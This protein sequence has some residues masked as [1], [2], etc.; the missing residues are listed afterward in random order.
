[1]L[2]EV[3]ED[4]RASAVEVS[5][6]IG[7]RNRGL[8]LSDCLR[9]LMAQTSAAPF[10]IVVVD[11]SSVDSTA[12]VIEGWRRRDDRIRLVAE[13]RIGLSC[14]KNAGIRS[15]RGDLLIFTDDDVVAPAGWVSSYVDLFRRRPDAMMA[16]GPVLPIQHDL[17]RGSRWLDQTLFADIKHMHR[18]AEEH[19]LP[20]SELAFGA[21]MAVRRRLFEEIGEFDESVGPP[22][23]DSWEDLEFVSRFRAAG[24]QPWYCPGALVYHRVS[25]RRLLAVVFSHGAND[26]LKARRGAPYR[27]R[28]PVPRGRVQAS[29]VLPWSL[30]LLVLSGGV[31]RL[32]GRP[33]TFRLARGLAWASGW[34]MSAAAWNSSGWRPGRMARILRRLSLLGRRLALRL[35]PG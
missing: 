2:D 30:A 11:N 25:P 28:V 16:G 33:S 7:T 21:N 34:C 32:V 31:F 5:I 4:G 17:G 35:M 14:A 15:A 24:G 12:V 20:E 22:D 19:P 8:W 29:L 1:M 26:A 10:E 23:R 27:T 18:G 13:P 6:V 3:T 9:S